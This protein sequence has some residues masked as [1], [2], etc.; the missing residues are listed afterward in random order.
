MQIRASVRLFA[1]SLTPD[2][3]RKVRALS[4]AGKARLLESIGLGLVSIA[5]RSFAT[6]STL[7]PLAWKNK[8]DGTPST[9]T[10]STRL[11][12]SLQAKVSGSGVVVSSDAPYAAIHQLGGLTRPHVIR[13][14][15][16]KALAF[17]GKVFKK[18]NHPGSRIPARPYLP[19]CRDGSLTVTAAR[20]VTALITQQV[21]GS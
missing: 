11:R 2:L 12:K 3:Q 17:G 8:K 19:F 9:L 7:R 16:K 4:G 15:R 5:K 14:K 21:E 18:V 20:N 6:D 13:A 1:N 10:K